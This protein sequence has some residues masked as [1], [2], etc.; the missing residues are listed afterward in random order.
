MH[1]I[2]I[3]SFC[4]ATMLT[5]L[6]VGEHTIAMPMDLNESKNKTQKIVIVGA[7]ISG[8][9][10]ARKLLKQGLT[11]VQII[12]ASSQPG[13]RI[14]GS[15][16]GKS[17]VPEGAQY[18]HGAS[19]KN[20]IFQLAKEYDLL[21]EIYNMS[22]A[23]WSVFTNTQKQLDHDFVEEMVNLTNFLRKQIALHSQGKGYVEVRSIG[24][25]YVEE[26]K[27]VFSNWTDDAPNFRRRKL[28]FLNMMTKDEC[29]KFSSQNLNDVSLQEFSYLKAE[30]KAL[31][32]PSLPEDK[33]QAI[34]HMGFGTTNK[35]FLEYEVPFWN[36]S[37]HWIG[38]VW[39]D[40]TPFSGLKPN[41]AEWWRRIFAFDVVHPVERYG[42]ILLGWSSGKEAE[43]METLSEEDL[44]SNITRILRQFTGK[45][46]PRPKNAFVTKWFSNPYTR[47]SYSHISIDSTG[48]MIDTLAEPLP[49][50]GDK[51]HPRKTM[52]ILFAG[53]ATHRSYHSTSHGALLS[54]W[55]EADRLI[56]HYS[57]SEEEHRQTNN[58]NPKEKIPKVVIIGAG[59]A[60]VAAAEKL[61]HQGFADV[62][63][64]EASSQPGG[65]IRSYPFG[66]SVVDEGA[67]YIHGASMK[68][69]IFQLAKQN[70]LLQQVY[71]K[72]GTEWSVLTNTQKLLDSDFTEEMRNL[73]SSILRR[74]HCLA[75]EKRYTQ[76]K[77]LAEVYSEEVKTLLKQWTDDHVELRIQKLALLSMSM[78]WQCIHL[79][80]NS[81]GDVS[82][83]EYREYKNIEGDDRNSPGL[84]PSLLQKLLEVIPEEKLLLE[85]PVKQIQWDGNFI[86]EDTSL[87]PV[88]V[89]CEDGNHILADH[90]IVTISLGCLKANS[91]SLFQ[92]SLPK[93]YQHAIQNMGFGTMNKIYLEYE[94]PFWDEN[95]DIIGLVW[96]DETPLSAQ[97]PNLA[98]WWRRVPVIYVFRPPERFGHVLVGTIS[99][100]EAEFVESLSPEE[101]ASNFTKLFRQFTGRPSLPAPKNAFVTKWFSNP[102]TRGSY[103]HISIDSTGDMIDTL[104]EPLPQ[105]KEGTS[106]PTMQI[107][108]AGE[109]THRSYHS[110]SHGALLSGWREADRLINHYSTK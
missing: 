9:G 73:A 106:S 102:Y 86:S 28:G 20:P 104:A 94:A 59:I 23:E 2:S 46:V 13:G 107:L 109:A 80:T 21:Q 69:P 95:T 91:Q 39:E 31:F 17:V 50:E 56:N 82:V 85:R 74:A 3:I 5:A 33:L 43:F 92:P 48:D 44:V 97:K 88:R 81:L 108:F 4:S 54:G 60:G 14:R 101:I 100:K 8:V 47:G 24:Q 68:N 96:E 37:E 63:I 55:R 10:A 34:K 41:L 65:R 105:A 53:E 30:A 35:I 84:F 103:S 26:L 78:K 77:S 12:E 45:P 6:I 36:S 67:Q 75:E 98:E 90:V 58:M 38:L 51:G 16:F 40:E 27:K 52:Q 61:Y 11:D 15:L 18:I 49:Q 89:V 1:S 7:G 62:Q 93:K 99:G 29:L 42:H 70:D 57:T 25:V 110:T 83:H 76:A 32:Q 19:M 22:G 71:N 64:I 66:K 72:S 79:A 87:Y